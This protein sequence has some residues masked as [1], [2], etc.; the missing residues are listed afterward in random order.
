[1]KKTLFALLTIIA[2][3]IS[4]GAVRAE[5][6]TVI[7]SENTVPEF[8]VSAENDPKDTGTLT[9]SIG[10]AVP[11][12]A[13]VNKCMLRVVPMPQPT[14]PRADQDVTVIWS[15][16]Q[17]GY[18]SAYSQTTEPYVAELMP[19]ACASG[20]NDFT[21]KTESQYT[22]WDYY[23]G[24]AGIAANQPRLIVTYDL[25]TP[26][27]S[28]QST[29][30]AYEKPASFFSSPLLELTDGQELLANPVFYDGAVYVIAACPA[31]RGRCLYRTT[32]AGRTSDGV[33]LVDEQDKGLAIE[34]NSFA[35]VTAWDRLQLIT[36]NAIHSC[37]LT[38]LATLG[39]AGKLVCVATEPDKKITVNSGE[40][41]AMGPDG[42]LYFKNVKAQG[43]IVAYNP[44]LRELWRT[45]GLMPT[46]I[47]PIALSVNGQY[48]YALAN[49]ATDT[50]ISALLRIDTATGETVSK[51][52]AYKDENGREV[53][54]QLQ[55]LL[56]PAVASKVINKRNVDYVFVAGN[57]S[58]TGI[59]QL[60]AFDQS[61]T[62]QVV[63]SRGGKVT[64]APVLG[65]QDGNSLFVVQ[66]G[67]LKRYLWYSTTE[68][69]T[70]AYSD[71]D[72]KEETLNEGMT[73]VTSLLV[74]GGDSVYLYA[75]KSLY[76]YQS[77]SKEMSPAQKFEKFVPK[78]L[79]T[80]DGSLIGYDDFRV[81]DLSPNAET[82]LLLST[83]VTGTVYSA[84]TVTVQVGAG[85][86]VNTGEWVILKGSSIKFQNGF[87]WPPG[88]TLKLQSV[89]KSVQ[90]TQ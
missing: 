88:A 76:A 29:D 27:R 14:P 4:S 51:E 9:F 21:L 62:P 10:P 35:F 59:L 16:K 67:M 13:P 41:P 12:G 70:G 69:S 54:P 66:D 78:L 31:D 37:D 56:R 5:I 30:W 85:E 17:V 57:T 23:G 24:G 46:T 25:P 64:T 7:L 86:A 80:P 87:R 60:V 18:W 33:P 65:V 68:N 20:L 15:G 28:G 43:S 77:A 58:D 2:A 61:A 40:T 79:F 72:M 3:F 11:D 84:D 55:K 89:Q 47:S 73:S 45:T 39:S 74:D 71:S 81:Y 19:E 36:T 82:S 50:P 22:K 44:S 53:K 90:Q 42:S 63:W 26:A 34:K 38:T 32:S 75:D 1:M 8:T 48:A 83:L 49:I 6:T 52:I